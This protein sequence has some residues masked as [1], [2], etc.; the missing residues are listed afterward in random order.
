ME[1]VSLRAVA[2]LGSAR[3]GFEYLRDDV[4]KRYTEESLNRG[5]QSLVG[6]QVTADEFGKAGD[7]SRLEHQTF[8]FEEVF[9]VL[10]PASRYEAVFL[11]FDRTESFPVEDVVAVAEAFLSA[12]EIGAEAG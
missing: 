8:A 6:N 2:T 7:F 9:V 1:G 10:V 3:R 12:S 11:S 5:Y 4:E